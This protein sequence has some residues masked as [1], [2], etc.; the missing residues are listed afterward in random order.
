MKKRYAYLLLFCVPALVAALIGTVLVAGGV[1][2]VLWLFV[3]G[4]NPWPAWSDGLFGGVLVLAF[5]TLWIGMMA[6]AYAAGK[7]DEPNARIGTRPVAIAVA[8]TALLVLLAVL[9]QYGVGN[10]GPKSDGELCSRYCA[11]KG[12]NG[13]GMP[14]QNSGATDC[15]CFDA[16]GREAV[17]V[18]I[19]AVKATAGK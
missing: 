10:L 16:Q 9:H 17:K 15:S 13:S 8:F 6:M 18:P 7:R 19:E 3:Y 4:D 11:G 12:F 5:S 14:P 2:G 1:A